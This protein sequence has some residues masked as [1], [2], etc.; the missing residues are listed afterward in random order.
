MQ[1]GQ[2]TVEYLALTLVLLI[3][4][5]L[6][7]RFQTPVGSL[8]R[9]LAHAVAPAHRRAPAHRPSGHRHGPPKHLS[10]P[11]LCPLALP[12]HSAPERERENR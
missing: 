3:S 11:C 2:A 1:R 7:V 5:C 4:G 8:A 9:A 10:H 12:I 6:L